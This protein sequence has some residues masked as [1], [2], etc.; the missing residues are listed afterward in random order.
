MAKSDHVVQLFDTAES[1]GD[2]V[3]AFLCDGLARGD[4]LLVV[5]RGIHVQA[6]TTALANH[7][8]PIQR[9]L[10][11]GRLVML[12]AVSVLRQ[13]LLEGMPGQER[14]DRVVG[15]LVRNLASNGA[16]VRIY[17]EMV[18]VLAEQMEFAAAIKLEELWNALSGSI[19]IT[20]L[21]GYASAHF[22]LTSAADRLRE[23]CAC[24]DRVIQ[25][26]SDILGSWVLNQYSAAT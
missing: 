13:L 12:D 5:A 14:F 16:C 9:L 10:E 8:V 22:A 11:S 26:Q 1:L 6:I 7:D 23:V 17:G 21:C 3:A 19:P 18:D 4:V 25:G 15:D 2:S 20:L 24:H